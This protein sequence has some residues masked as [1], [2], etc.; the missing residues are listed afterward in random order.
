[1]NEKVTM[2]SGC[3]NKYVPY[4]SVLISSIISNISDKNDYEFLIFDFDID[5]INKE[6]L[7]N[8]AKGCNNFA[9]RIIKID[10]HIIEQSKKWN[11][12]RWSRE[13]YILFL[14]PYL[15]QEYNKIIYL[16]C[17]V[18]NLYDLSELFDV[19]IENYCIGAVRLLGRA[20][21]RDNKF[22]SEIDMDMN[23]SLE[24]DQFDGY[25][26]NG[27]VLF[28][29]KEFRSLY[30]LEWIFG[31]LS[32]QNYPLLDQDCINFLCK[33]K[34]KYIDST[35]NVYPY[36]NSEMDNMM[37]MC[38]KEYIEYFKNCH[39]HPK[40]IHYTTPQKPWIEPLGMYSESAII[41]WKYAAQSPFYEKL[42]KEMIQYHNAINAFQK[43]KELGWKDFENDAKC[44]KVMIYGFGKNGNSVIN[45]IKDHYT[46]S[47]I[48][49]EDSEKYGLKD[50]IEINS[51]T[52]FSEQGKDSVIIISN[53]N[54][55]D[56]F[57]MLYNSG[58]K[59]LYVYECMEQLSYDI[60]VNDMAYYLEAA[61]VF[62]DKKSRDVFM[63]IINRKREY[64]FNR[65]IKLIDI[66]EGG[67][68]FYNDLFDLSLCKCYLDI[69]NNAYRTSLY[70]K[71][72]INRTDI[73]IY[74]INSDVEL[75]GL[76]IHPDF[77][78]IDVE[79]TQATLNV[80]INQCIINDVYMA[81]NVS[82]RNDLWCIPRM[83]RDLLPNAN[84][85]LRHHNTDFSQTI[86]YVVN[87]RGEL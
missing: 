39:K 43:Y 2:V 14:A 32:E 68:Y 66:F 7:C 81:I 10:S 70:F 86:L 13:L 69:G 46:I 79:D 9:I 83:I 21:R 80:L 87:N 36:T 22:L 34:V 3:N 1:M 28:N 37:N 44:N 58:Y 38:P 52:Y 25:F 23:E 12:G 17:D 65:N 30:S 84:L 5:E 76:V 78:K 40:N 20:V 33:G 67:M 64:S 42:K 50:N 53:H 31:F 27:I 51:L 19:N 73:E 72:Y 60:C 8:I 75:M 47:G 56:I 18:I 4:L 45:R 24:I 74:A 55:F 57:V 85:Y 82:K 62:S 15:L 16:D 41:F 54:Y 26:N 11:I 59:K 71:E 63:T 48:V 35:W 77:V 6:I 49:D 29:L 61:T